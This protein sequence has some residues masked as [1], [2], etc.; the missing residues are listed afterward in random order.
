MEHDIHHLHIQQFDARVKQWWA[1][2][3]TDEEL[4]RVA[5]GACSIREVLQA[6]ALA[7]RQAPQESQS[8]LRDKLARGLGLGKA[9]VG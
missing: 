2:E 1:D 3:L 7:H 6:R 9:R 5:S 8:S 4:D